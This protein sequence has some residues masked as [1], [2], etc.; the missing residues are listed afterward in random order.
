MVRLDARNGEGRGEGSVDEVTRGGE[1]GV[2]RDSPVPLYRQLKVLIARDITSGVL[3]PDD[4]IGSESELSRRYGVSR[5]TVRGALGELQQEGLITRIVG[6]GTFVKSRPAAGRM[7]RLAG[8]AEEIRALGLTPIYE[9]LLVES[10]PAGDEVGENLNLRPDEHVYYIERRLLA[11]GQPV[12]YGESYLPAHLF[13]A[14]DTELDRSTLDR[15]SLYDLLES[16]A[17]VTLDNAIERVWPRRADSRG[18][19]LLEIEPGDLLLEVHRTVFDTHGRAIEDVRLLY[20]DTRYAYR[21]QL[22][23]S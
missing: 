7:T 17:G 1:V 22:M 19:R 12:A 11:E 23:R 8:F 13:D 20:A 3:Q 2:R 9:T 21:V 10:R 16:E 6:R 18:S 4:P 5:I 14:L 15:R